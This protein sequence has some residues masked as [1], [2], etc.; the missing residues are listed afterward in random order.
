MDAQKKAMVQALEKSLGIVTAA[1]K[2]VG[3]SRQ[4]HYNWLKEDEDYRQKVEAIPEVVLD[5]A[6]NQL[7]K[8]IKNGNITATIFFLKTRGKDR[9]YIERIQQEDITAKPK[10]LV[11]V[12]K[13]G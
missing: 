4:T 13:D 5:F 9:G 12:R 10:Q 6:E 2:V 8:A 1:C 3:I 7:Y 11:I